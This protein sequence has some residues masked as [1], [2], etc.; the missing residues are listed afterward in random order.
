MWHTSNGILGRRSSLKIRSFETFLNFPAKITYG[1]GLIT[2]VDYH[3]IPG[4]DV[5]KSNGPDVSRGH[6]RSRPTAAVD[7]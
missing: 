1:R 4:R 5:G 6:E 7:Q 3:E 2:V